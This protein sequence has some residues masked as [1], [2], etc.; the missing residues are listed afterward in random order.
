[1]NFPQRTN[2][3]KW[4]IAKMMKFRNSFLNPCLRNTTITLSMLGR[5]RRKNSQ[6]HSLKSGRTK[7]SL[8]MKTRKTI[9]FCS[10]ITVQAGC[11]WSI[12]SGTTKRTK[13]VSETH[14]I[15]QPK[16]KTRNQV[17]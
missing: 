9:T 10:T 12:S 6:I 8:K 7:A 2:T 15:S 11:R 3:K 13:P 5:K 1:M 14:P 16:G 17:S 4:T